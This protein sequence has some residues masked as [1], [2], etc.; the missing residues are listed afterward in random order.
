MC[1]TPSHLPSAGIT[2]VYHSWP[3]SQVLSDSC[4][5]AWFVVPLATVTECV[6]V[7][8]EATGKMPGNVSGIC[9]NQVRES[10]PLN[11][12]NRWMSVC[13]QVLALLNVP[14]HPLVCCF[15]EEYSAGSQFNKTG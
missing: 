6:F 2:G 13:C 14:H 10:S 7:S 1:T 8:K 9:W 4:S 3:P 15:F 11:R 5:H 12:E